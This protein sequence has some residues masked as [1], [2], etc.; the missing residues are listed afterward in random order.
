MKIK[1]IVSF[2]IIFLGVLPIVSNAQFSMA[3][4]GSGYSF[5]NS[6]DDNIHIG[7]QLRFGFD[8]ENKVL[9]FGGTYFLPVIS[10]DKIKAYKLNANTNLPPHITL[11]NSVEAL[12]FDIFSDFHYYFVGVPIDSRG[13]Y[14]IAGLGILYYDQTYNLSNFNPQDYYSPEYI[15]GANYA[16]TQFTIDFGI[17]GKLPMRKKSWYYELKFTF[18]TDPY[19]DYGKGV[20]GSHYISFNTGINFHLKTRKSKYQ[21]SAMGRTKKQRKK[22]KDRI[23][24]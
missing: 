22:S 15:D 16:S 10:K 6:N 2:L 23:R 9:N 19:K 13:F 8:W 21:R 3:L 24:R 5:I 20:Q 18:L 7:P 12:S 4:G 17:G 11:I 14:G 1:F